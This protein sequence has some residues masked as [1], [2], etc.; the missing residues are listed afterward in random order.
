MH[1]HVCDVERERSSEGAAVGRVPLLP[2]SGSSEGAPNG[3][4]R[5]SRHR[6]SVVITLHAV[7]LML[8]AVTVLCRIAGGSEASP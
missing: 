1:V 3:A 7:C 5:A 8:I 4:I 6:R 2:V